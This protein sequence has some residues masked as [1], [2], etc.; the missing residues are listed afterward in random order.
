M[1]PNPTD[2]FINVNG[3]VEITEV[4]IYDGLGRLVTHSNIYDTSASINV[5]SF[6]AGI[7]IVLINT[8]KGILES[9]FIK[10]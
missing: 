2:D 6:E 5:S 8:E 3:D 4:S 10:E 9:K 1:Y 7:Y